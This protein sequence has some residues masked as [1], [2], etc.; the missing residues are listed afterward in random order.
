MTRSGRVPYTRKNQAH[1]RGRATLRRRLSGGDLLSDQ[2]PRRRI[3]V[4]LSSSSVFP[5]GLSDTFRIADHLG[6]DGVEVMVSASHL[7]RDVRG[8]RSLS[9]AH[10]QP[11]L[12]LHAPTLFFLQHVWGP[13]PWPKIERTVQ[14]AVDLDTPVVVAH[15]PFR[16]QT[17]Y[18]R[19]FVDGVAALEAEYGVQV[20][21]ENMYPWRLGFREAMIYLP[22]HDPTD[23]PY[24]HCTIDLSHAATAG[25]DVLAMLDRLGDRLA[26]LHLADGSGRTTKDEHRPPGE[27]NQPCAEVLRRLANRGFSG[28][29]VVEVTTSTLRR[30]GAREE[31]LRQCL[32]FARAHLAHH[33]A[34]PGV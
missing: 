33:I 2:M 26:H 5:L 15:P 29:V 34:E 22:S 23:Q 6:Y 25:D 12:S 32:S 9:K 21:V 13:S 28:S 31:V 20:A 14:M 16:W 11:I 7:S 30:P 19:E 18:A 24:N 8:L 1:R 10:H 17:R 3:P 27:G 4:G